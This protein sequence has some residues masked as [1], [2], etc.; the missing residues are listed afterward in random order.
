MGQLKSAKKYHRSEVQDGDET[1]NSRVKNYY[2][3]KQFLSV[4]I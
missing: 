2:G 1:S 3:M 4:F